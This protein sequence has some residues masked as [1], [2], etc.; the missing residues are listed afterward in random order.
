M[1]S[2]MAEGTV[3]Q[4]RAEGLEPTFADCV[5]LNDFGLRVERDA[6]A[7]E[8]ASVP[9]CAFLGDWVLWEPTLAKMMWIDR[10]RQ[11]LTDD[12][13]TQVALM[14]YALNTDAAEL[15]P[16]TNTRKLAKAV[17]SFS[18]EV[19]VF[20]TPSQIAAAIDIAIRGPEDVDAPVAESE[21]SD[22]AAVMEIPQAVISRARDL[23]VTAGVAGLTPE[24][25][26]DFPLPA[27]DA[28]VARALLVRYKKA[29][30][31]KTNLVGDYYVAAGKIRAR[32][33]EEKKAKEVANG[34]GNA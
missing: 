7:V 19:L 27:V 25:V 15:P 17:E 32:L 13:E 2:K 21:K 10:A 8:F 31:L 29:A 23:I 18:R 33:T 1:I 6:N 3:A 22:R 26:R 20:F 5:T 24:L 9:R 34:T 12:A 28:M 14:A 30:S 4:M 16:L 11:L